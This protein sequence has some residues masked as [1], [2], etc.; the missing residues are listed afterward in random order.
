MTDDEMPEGEAVRPFAVPITGKFAE[1][2]AGVL[3]SYREKAENGFPDGAPAEGSP[4]MTDIET[5]TAMAEPEA[6][7]RRSLHSMLIDIVGLSFDTALDHVRSLEHDIVRDPAPVW[8]PLVS[9]R[10]VLESCLFLEYLIDPSISCGLR[11]ARCAGLWRK[12]TDHAAKAARVFGPEEHAQAA[13][14]DAYV[15]RALA[16]AKVVER[17]NAKGTLVGY[18]VDGDTA[19]LDFSIT[20]RARTALP[21]WIPMPYGLLSGAAH[22]RPWMTDRARM[23]GMD[24]GSGL[25]GEAATVMTALMVAMASLEMSLRAWQGYFGCDLGETLTELEGHFRHGQLYLLA[26]AHAGES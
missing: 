14:M 4:F 20:E 5:M 15:T 3:K 21:S 10:A 23:A 12:D 18:E 26:M 9:A 22:S 17:R 11:L 25:V 2:A 1:A 24:T 19:P 7:A 16:E 6:T 8:S 13:H